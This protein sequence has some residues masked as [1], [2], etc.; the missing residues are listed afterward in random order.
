[1]PMELIKITRKRGL[2]LNY[3]IFRILSMLCKIPREPMK[4]KR[5]R[6]YISDSSSAS[7]RLDII[8]VWTEP[9]N[10]SNR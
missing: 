5:K 10:G 1:M 3:I 4:N 2:Y 7:Y 9:H 6:C 8:G